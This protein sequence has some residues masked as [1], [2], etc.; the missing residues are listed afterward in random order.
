MRPAVWMAFI[1]LLASLSPAVRGDK[2]LGDITIPRKGPPPTDVMPQA[3]FPHW[4]HRTRY[5]CYACHDQLFQMKA[6]ADNITM[7]ALSS[8]KF[9][10]VCHNGKIAFAVGFDT[11]ELCH[12]SNG[13]GAH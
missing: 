1:V 7:D 3:V 13:A 11:C 8:G 10:A 6:G 4:K 2:I 9:C 5:K 12:S